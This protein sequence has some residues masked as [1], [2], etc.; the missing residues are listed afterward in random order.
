MPQKTSSFSIIQRLQIVFSISIGLLLISLIA[1]VYST[2]GLIDNS[3]LVN[4][5]NEV[6]R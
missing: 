4:H 2:N 3:K 1:S 5:T 6:L